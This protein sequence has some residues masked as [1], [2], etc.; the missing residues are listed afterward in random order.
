MIRDSYNLLRHVG[1]EMLLGDVKVKGQ[2]GKA[3][4]IHVPSGIV[5]G[6][7]EREGDWRG[8]EWKITLGSGSTLRWGREN[9]Q[10]A[11]E[12]VLDP[13]HHHPGIVYLDRPGYEDRVLTE[14]EHRL[15]CPEAWAWWDRVRPLFPP[16]KVEEKKRGS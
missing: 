9:R 1:A 7:V 4:V 16:S 10:E 3:E 8:A 11:V 13:R 14:A 2:K 5:L 6:T 12:E 15:A